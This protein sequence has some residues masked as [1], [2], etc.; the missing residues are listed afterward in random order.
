MKKLVIALMAFALV[1]SL[2]GC[3]GGGSS[4][5]KDF[6][7][8]YGDNGKGLEANFKDVKT[9]YENMS[10]EL[11]KHDSSSD[12]KGTER[13]EAIV[14]YI[15]DD[16]KGNTKSGYTKILETKDKVA[17]RLVYLISKKK[18]DGLQMIPYQTVK[19]GYKAGEYVTE[20]TK[21]YVKNLVQD[22]K[23]WPNQEYNFKNVK[24]V[25]ESTGWKIV[26]G[27]DELGMT[28]SDF[29]KDL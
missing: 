2:A 5:S 6:V 27:L 12:P 10:A 8:D 11:A 9:A 20:N 25:K 1:I 23:N 26:S 24:W 17:D 19:G 28:S 22:G 4:S 29:F 7:L 13:A 14:K 3:G 16:Y 15:S 21:L 18:F